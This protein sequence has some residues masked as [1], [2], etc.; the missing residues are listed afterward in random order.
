MPISL[1]EHTVAPLE[2]MEE[3][4][5]KGLPSFLLPLPANFG[6]DTRL[7]PFQKKKKKG[8]VDKSAVCWYKQQP[9]CCPPG[10]RV[11]CKGTDQNKE[12]I[13]MFL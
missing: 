7:A 2:V 1:L 5:K 3:A 13:G 10:V 4:P 12:T 9:N 6:I 11:Y 8:T